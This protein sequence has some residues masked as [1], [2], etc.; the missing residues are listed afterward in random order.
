LTADKENRADR[1]EEE[2]EAGSAP[3]MYGNILVPIDGTDF[4]TRAVEHAV[5]LARA[6]GARLTF[7][8]VTEPFYLRPAPGP[9]K[10]ELELRSADVA[11]RILEAAAEQA[12]AAGVSFETAHFVGDKPAEAIMQAAVEHGCDLIVMASHGRR[13]LSALVSGSETLRVLQRSSTPLL[14][15]RPWKEKSA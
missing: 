7:L 15:L 1:A 10:A 8:T 14:V 6:V 9:V 11:D 5:K 13:C 4:S 2:D 12:E 3:M